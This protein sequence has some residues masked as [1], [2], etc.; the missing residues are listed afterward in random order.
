MRVMAT[1]ILHVI[2]KI[3]V[4]S[5]VSTMVMNYY[6]KMDHS[7]ITFDFMLNEDTDEATRSFIESNGSKLFIMPALKTKNLVLYVRAL[8]SFYSKN[9]YKIIHG[10]VAN[11]AVFYLGLAKHVPYKIIHSHSTELSDVFWK[12]IRN[13]V[14]TR[15]IKHV[16]NLYVACSEKAAVSLFGSSHKATIIENAIDVRKFTFS[17]ENRQY[18]RS[19]L[20]LTDEVVVGHVGRFCEAKNH[21]FILSVFKDA[22]EANSN[23]RLLL[24]GDGELRKD[25]AKRAKALEIGSV[26]YF[27]GKRSDVENCLSAMDILILPSIFEGLGLAGIEAQASGLRVLASEFVPKAMDITGNVKFLPLDRKLW[28]KHLLLNTECGCDRISQGNKV[29]GSRYDVDTQIEKLYR[30]YEQFL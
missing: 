12:K 26:V 30:Y 17:E 21:R 22:Y 9:I 13:W 5:G 25:I 18:I 19:G 14:L 2:D 6:K 7:R 10:H 1:R 29:L 15:C 20:G 8:N 3:S 4:D 24:V 27:L 11:S 23:L 28:V 16:A